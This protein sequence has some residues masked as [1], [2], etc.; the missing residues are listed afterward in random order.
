METARMFRSETMVKK[1]LELYQSELP[2]A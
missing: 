1:Y 2:P